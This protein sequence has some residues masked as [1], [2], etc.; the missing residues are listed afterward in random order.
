M[1]PRPPVSRR[2]AAPTSKP[3][4][5][6]ST[7]PAPKLAPKV[8]AKTLKKDEFSTGKARALRAKTLG[9]SATAAVSAATG[10]GP[11][12]QPVHSFD[13]ATYLSIVGNP[14]TYRMTQQQMDSLRQNGMQHGVM[15]MPNPSSP[16]FVV[17]SAA[18][19][20]ELQLLNANGIRTDTYAY[21]H[22]MKNGVARPDAAVRDQVFK[23]LDT[24]K[25]Q[26]VK[27]FWLDVEFDEKL[28]PSAGPVQNQRILDTAYQAFTD[29]KTANPDS[30]LEF[31]IYTGKGA[32]DSMLKGGAD[33]YAT[34]YAEKGVPLWQAY[35]P[36][37][38]EPKNLGTG[39]ADMKANLGAGFGGWSVDKGNV[40]GWQYRAGEHDVRLP[41]FNIGVDRNVWLQDANQ[42]ALPITAR[43][44]GYRADLP[45]TNQALYALIK[46]DQG[47]PVDQ[48]KYKTLQDLIN[49][50][51]HDGV[52]FRS[53]GIS[54]TACYQNRWEDPWKLVHG[55]PLGTDQFLSQPLPSTPVTPT[56]VTPAPVTPAPVTPAPVTPAPVTPI[57]GSPLD[58]LNAK[59]GMT[60]APRIQ[61][62][63]DTLMS[64]G[65][66]ADIKSNA[67]YGKAF[68]PVT[69]TA[70][71]AFQKDQLIAQTGVVDRATVAA[72]AKAT[73]TSLGF[74]AASPFAPAFGLARG[75]NGEGDRPGIK[76]LQD[77][78]ING[79]Y[80]PASMKSQTGYGTN[81][82]PLTEAGLKA[83]Q[84]ENGLNPS[85]VVD[86]AT[87]TALGHPRARP[88]GFAAGLAVT[89][90]PQLGLPTGAPYT[91]A[92]GSL[93]QDFDRGSVW[94]SKERVLHV[95]AQ[96][97]A[98]LQEL[99]PPRKLGT[100]QSLEEARASFLSQWGPTAYND[101]VAG[102]DIP[103]G[104]S[105]CGPTSALMA[106]SA[107]G[108][109][110]RP[111]AADASVAIDHMR[112]QILGYDSTASLG[113][114][115]LP[116][117]K[118]TVGYGLQA[119]GAKVTGISSTVTD[120]DAALARGNP[121]IIGT[122]STWSAWGQVEQRAGNYLNNGDPHGHFVTVLGRSANGNYL[123]GDPLLRG[124]PIEVT[125]AQLQTAISGAFNSSTAI[126]EISRP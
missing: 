5:A 87:V 58:L 30:K 91:A 68:G 2:A 35:Y 49:A 24:L 89:Y 57:A 76:A 70:L 100:A 8:A 22:W 104:Y 34:K 112:D 66:L 93:R 40:R 69:E 13:T 111:G 10:G 108:L 85:G 14:P 105:D 84:S 88:A 54:E 53:L 121:V 39:L 32:W 80:A 47:K 56:P 113:L 110:S 41:A 75:A 6:K 4:A 18:L 33:P 62:L 97:P 26:P 114:S 86:A 123:I 27:T 78:L 21:L 50:N 59:R 109:M 115:L 119:A 52:S 37:R 72:L 46:G 45:I 25:G 102:S 116:P 64:L 17:E 36:E 29:W 95:Q 15:G 126:A 83:F 65:Y 106:L 16:T 12:L 94:V 124:G 118:G 81:F 23:T 67:G 44:S 20:Q 79:G 1:T 28:N 3:A 48:R 125:Q 31:G 99:A 74:D 51:G 19:K 71:K 117:V 42:P 107:L 7:K 90:R 101:P 96:T 82:G 11:Q 60:D 43:P 98:G 77:V 63:Q 9:T 103:Y 61:Q 122:N 120:V 38:Y 55:L 73:H 92:D